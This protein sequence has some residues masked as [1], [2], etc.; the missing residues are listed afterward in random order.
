MGIEKFDIVTWVKNGAWALPTTMKRLDDVLPNE[1][2][3]RKI[4]VDDRSTDESRDIAKDFN[5]EVYSNPSSGISSGA[6]YAL[7]KVDCPFFMSVEQDLFLAK[8]WWEKIS[9]LFVHDKVSAA[10][11]VRLVN[12]PAHVRKLEEYILQ[13]EIDNPR[14]D[15]PSFRCGK[16]LDNTLWNTRIVKQVGGFPH[17]NRGTGV[18]TVLSYVLYSQGYE[19]VVNRSVVS[20][21]MRKGNIKQELAHQ[22]WYASD[23]KEIKQKIAEKTNLILPES[24]LS[25]LLRFGFSPFRAFQIALQKRDARICYLYPLMRLCYCVGYFGGK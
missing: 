10:S 12:Q 16:F 14:W 13:N 20:V 15:Q 3:H 19:W 8:N 5:W 9:P 22:Y 2:V 1:M 21:H 23:F 18:D 24:Y 7:S 11:G 25:L 17:I 6:N 4:M